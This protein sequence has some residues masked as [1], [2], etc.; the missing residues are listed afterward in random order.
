MDILKR[1]NPV[2]K[3]ATFNGKLIDHKMSK[4]ELLQVIEWLSQ[5]RTKFLDKEQEQLHAAWKESEGIEV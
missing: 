5:E 4:Y 3:N 2:K 1:K